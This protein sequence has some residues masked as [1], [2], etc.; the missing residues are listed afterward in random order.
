MD[1]F[2]KKNFKRVLHFDF[3]HAILINVADARKQKAKRKNKK[4]MLTSKNKDV[5][6]RKSQLSDGRVL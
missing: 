3:H 4:T 2:Y 5:N 1:S 6:I